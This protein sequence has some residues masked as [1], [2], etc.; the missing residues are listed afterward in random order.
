MINFMFRALLGPVFV[1]LCKGAGALAHYQAGFK[2]LLSGILAA[3]G[4]TLS[5]KETGSAARKS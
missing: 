1:G 4:L 2:P 3:L 5:L